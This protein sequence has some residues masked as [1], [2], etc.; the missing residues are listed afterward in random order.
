MDILTHAT[1]GLI[2][3]SPFAVNSPELAG[4]ILLGSVLPDV[5][6]FSRIFGKRTFLAWHQTWTHSLPLTLGLSVALTLCSIFF[7]WNG[8]QLGIGL[9]FGMLGHILLD[10]SNTLGVA[11]LKPFSN[12]RFCLEWVFFI[13]ATVLAITLLTTGRIVWNWYQGQLENY[14]ASLACGIL[15]IVYWIF[16]GVL[17]SRAGRLAPVG[18]VSL[19]P[20]AL[21]PWKFLCAKVEKDEAS[22]FYLNACT[23]ATVSKHSVPIHDAI[24]KP[25]LAQLPEFKI[26]QELSPAYHVVDVVNEERGK[27]ILC[28]DLRTRNFGTSFGDL[29][30][31]LGETNQITRIHFYV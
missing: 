1:I 28:R 25:L 8:L 29:T 6:T 21:T 9:F 27:R 31:W 30:V 12:R 11:L 22:L 20:S 24:F 5:D 2:A 14:A 26:M 16:K 10:Y 15:L 23:G 18:T 13:D 4:G 17:R 7:D 3:A 19:L